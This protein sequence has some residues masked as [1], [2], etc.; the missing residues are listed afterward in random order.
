[1]I[2][3]QSVVLWIKIHRSKPYLA[4]LCYSKKSIKCFKV[5]FII[6]QYS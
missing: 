6:I 1:M 4:H 2:K 3:E 5:G